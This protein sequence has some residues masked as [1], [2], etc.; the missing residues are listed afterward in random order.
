L[1]QPARLRTSKW[2]AVVREAA[3][4]T[5]G[6]VLLFHGTPALT[7]Y[8]ADCGGHTSSAHD[9]WGG[10]GLSY[11]AGVRDGGASI[12]HT[13]WTFE[14]RTAALRDALNGDPRTSIGRRL[15]GIDI[16]QQD[17]A[18]RADQLTLHG[19]RTA[20]VRG[21]VFREVVSRAFG[22]RS[23]RSTLFSITRSGD[24]YV[25]SGRGFGH[26]VGLCQAGALARLQSGSTPD[27]VLAFYFPGTRLLH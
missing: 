17:A 11:L 26:G 7:V 18:G 13:T 6:Q 22:V 12:T 21:E 23:L 27:K 8:H 20:T 25:F 14:S 2:T 15:D 19:T 9:V 5:S 4:R 1:Y 16:T 3:R 10:D 24:E